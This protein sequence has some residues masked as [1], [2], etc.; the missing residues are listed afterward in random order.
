MTVEQANANLKDRLFSGLRIGLRDSLR[1]LNDNPDV[2]YT[3]LMVAA[4]KSE[5]KAS[6]AS[7]GTEKSKMGNTT[8]VQSKS[9]MSNLYQDIHEKANDEWMRQQVKHVVDGMIKNHNLGLK[10]KANKSFNGK[11]GSFKKPFPSSV[12]T[13]KDG[14]MIPVCYRCGGCGHISTDCPSEPDVLN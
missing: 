11:G 2:D 1:Y 12:G 5:A 3:R 14:K 6:L 8:K 4:R 10:G 7:D 13:Y 9:G